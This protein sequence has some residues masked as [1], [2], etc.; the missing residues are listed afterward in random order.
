MALDTSSVQGSEFVDRAAT[1]FVFHP[2]QA[3]FDLEESVWARAQRNTALETNAEAIRKALYCNFKAFIL[4]TSYYSYFGAAALDQIHRYEGGAID[5]PSAE[6]KTTASE[7]NEVKFLKPLQGGWV[8]KVPETSRTPDVALGPEDRRSWLERT[9]NVASGRRMHE[10]RLAGGVIR[11]QVRLAASSSGLILAQSVTAQPKKADDLKIKDLAALELDPQ[12]LAEVARFD[13]EARVD[14]LAVAS[15]GL[16]L[17]SDTRLTKRI[18]GVR[19]GDLLQVLRIVDQ[20]TIN[21]RVAQPAA[22]GSATGFVNQHPVDSGRVAVRFRVVV[23]LIPG[24]VQYDTKVVDPILR[25]SVLTDMQ[26]RF[27]SQDKLTGFAR[28][29]IAADKFGKLSAIAGRTVLRF[30]PSI[31]PSTNKKEEAED[32]VWVI[33]TLLPLSR[34]V[35]LRLLS[36]SGLSVRPED[37]FDLA[38]FAEQSASVTLKGAEALSPACTAAA[39]ESLRSMKRKVTAFVQFMPDKQRSDSEQIRSV[40]NA[41]G[42][43]TPAAEKVIVV[44]QASEIRMC[45]GQDKSAAALARDLLEKCELG[46][47]TPRETSTCRKGAPRDTIEI[48][49]GPNAPG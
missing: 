48:V 10:D 15:A 22:N 27:P 11:D 37:A 24:S 35:R 42:F 13:P 12:A 33:M 9:L 30:V 46:R 19:A 4:Q 18:A 14:D 2:T 28:A 7:S 20:D 36:S 41:G 8:A 5:C 47:F 1:S 40:L 23:H 29:Q 25:S 16:G 49:L 31:L 32:S 3:A 21:V 17:F 34:D 43:Y 44:P 26:V 39:G 38:G 45:A 6:L